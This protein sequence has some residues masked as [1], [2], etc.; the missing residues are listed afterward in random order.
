[1]SEVLLNNLHAV[2]SRLCVR[3]WRM[4][5]AP[6]EV[7]L[8][9]PLLRGVWGAALYEIDRLLYEILFEGKPLGTTGYLLR[10]CT[11]GPTAEPALEFVLF[12]PLDARGLQL[13]WTAWDVALQR[14]LGPRRLPTH[15]QRTQPL[16]WDGTLLQPSRL[17][18]GFSLA[19]LPWPVRSDR[20]CRLVFLSPLRLLREQQLLLSPTL[21]DLTLAALRRFSA[22]A[23]EAG[24]ASWQERSAWLELARRQ[25]ALPFR[26]QPRDLIRYSGRQRA[27]IELRGVVGELTLLEGPGPLADL[28]CAATW[29]HL[30]KSTVQGMGLM[31]IQGEPL[32]L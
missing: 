12:G 24:K 6:V 17:H 30:G 13:V 31:T 19:G 10:P 28:L 23:P 11:Q 15:L 20:P 18:P 32:S 22:Q 25:P 2:L 14:G 7:E 4:T 8:T 27:E 29:L 1:M 21:A 26:G 16:A 9:V 3:A 5:L